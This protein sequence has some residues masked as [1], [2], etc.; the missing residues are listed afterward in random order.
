[1]FLI[2]LL[3]IYNFEA[4]SWL[5]CSIAVVFTTIMSILGLIAFRKLFPN[6][7]NKENNS[8]VS[9]SLGT[10]S[11]FSSVLISL[12]VI[13]VW[14][15]YTGVEQ[16][17]DL[18]AHYSEDFYRLAQGMPQPIQ[19]Q[20]I[21]DIKQYI[22]IVVDEEWPAMTANKPI[23][24]KGRQTLMHSND[25]LLHFQT[26][27]L[28]AANFQS[29]LIDKLGSLFD[30]RRDRIIATKGHVPSVIWLVMFISSFLT[31]AMCYL[32]TAESFTMHMISTG[33]VAASLAATLFLIVIFGHPF[34]GNMRIK[35]SN[36]I[37]FK[38]QNLQMSVDPKA[39]P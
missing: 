18:E 10:V 33:F 11:L 31:V 19:S 39:N 14:N 17:V 20:L 15:S 21:N 27:N 35:L 30:V 36:F 3:Y 4:P 12:I 38:N 32:S 7:L 13:N 29:K 28:S 5:I 16:T 34:Q 9:F 24:D 8:V 1:M 22:D 37:S 25:L 26:T 23:S 6:F 2:N